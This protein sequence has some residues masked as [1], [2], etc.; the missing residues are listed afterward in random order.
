M[1]KIPTIKINLRHRFNIG[2]KVTYNKGDE[3]TANREMLVVD[4]DYKNGT[5]IIVSYKNSMNKVVEEICNAND[6]EPV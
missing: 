4:F 3:L 1:S 6:L 2:D 5:D